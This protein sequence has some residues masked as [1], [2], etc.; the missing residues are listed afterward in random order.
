MPG[1][2][3]Q[4]LRNSSLFHMDKE[5]GRVRALSSSVMRGGIGPR[6][7]PPFQ[8]YAQSVVTIAGKKYLALPKNSSGANTSSTTSGVSALNNVDTAPT[9]AEEETSTVPSDPAPPS[10][11]PPEIVAT[12]SLSTSTEGE[13]ATVTA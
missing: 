11:P 10:P 2:I 12:T 9:A 6:A 8:R 7:N 4:G 5:T 1:A 3:G 13:A